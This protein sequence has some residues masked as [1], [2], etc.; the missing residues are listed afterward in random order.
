MKKDFDCVE[1]KRAI[2][3]EIYEEIKDL[4]D[5]ERTEYFRRNAESGSLA[6]FWK[7]LKTVDESRAEESRHRND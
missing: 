7:S 2:Q 5:R 1:M 4:S 3:A 6:E